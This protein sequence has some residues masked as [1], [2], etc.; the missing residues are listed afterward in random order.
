MFSISSTKSLELIII[1]YDDTQERVMMVNFLFFY[2]ARNDGEKL[3][4][5]QSDISKNIVQLFGENYKYRS[6]VHFA[7]KKILQILAKWQNNGND[8][9]N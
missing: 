6:L 5:T 9:I 3:K 8:S 2:L 4:I 1:E 7:A